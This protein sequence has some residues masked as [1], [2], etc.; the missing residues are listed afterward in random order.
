MVQCGL[1]AGFG[2]G[3]CHAGKS[4]LGLIIIMSTSPCLTAAPLLYGDIK[5]H[6]A[7]SKFNSGKLHQ[8]H[9]DVAFMKFAI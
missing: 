8:H 1:E 9:P 2:G 6:T 5:S 4:H 3:V 7:I